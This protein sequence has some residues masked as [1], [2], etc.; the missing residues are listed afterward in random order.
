MMLLS[1]S[2]PSF[3]GLRPLLFL[4]VYTVGGQFG[5]ATEDFSN[6]GKLIEK[7]TFGKK[8]NRCV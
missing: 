1:G 2:E 5:K 4:E 7:T 6:T 3:D 8:L